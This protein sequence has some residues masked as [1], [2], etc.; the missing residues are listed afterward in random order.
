MSI[1]TF[2]LS[3]L[4]NFCLAADNNSS[5]SSSTQNRTRNDEVALKQEDNQLS[6]DFLKYVDFDARKHFADLKSQLVPIEAASCMSPV[7]LKSLQ[8]ISNTIGSKA[9][10]NNSQCE[11]YVHS[12][13]FNLAKLFEIGKPPQVQ[14]VIFDAWKN[15]GFSAIKFMDL[16]KESKPHLS[17]GGHCIYLGDYASLWHFKR[18]RFL[19]MNEEDSQE[20]RNHIDQWATINFLYHG[21]V[22]LNAS[23][24]AEFENCIIAESFDRICT[25]AEKIVKSKKYPRAELERFRVSRLIDTE[26][27]TEGSK[28][29]LMASAF[30][31]KI[32][33]AW[34]EENYQNIIANLLSHGIHFDVKSAVNSKE[35]KEIVNAYEQCISRAA[36]VDTK[37]QCVQAV[38]LIWNIASIKSDVE[39]LQNLFNKA[40]GPANSECSF[41]LQRVVEPAII[42]INSKRILE[43]LENDDLFSK[44]LNTNGKKLRKNSNSALQLENVELCNRL[45]LIQKSGDYLRHIDDIAYIRKDFDKMTKV[46][47]TSE[48]YTAFLFVDEVIQELKRDREGQRCSFDLHRGKLTCSSPEMLESMVYMQRSELACKMLVD[49]CKDAVAEKSLATAILN[50][51]EQFDAHLIAFRAKFSGIDRLKPSCILFY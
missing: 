47:N 26:D 35:P 18:G 30:D 7:Q 25:L 16:A 28:I 49:F 6:T 51:E 33:L 29:T 32:R 1:F 24:N 11:E 23:D 8:N 40:K 27:V 31:M 22:I 9:L 21:L 48:R 12:A 45:F 43:D 36:N 17:D 13:N 38:H 34:E 15:S 5:N 20:G 50:F 41:M 2:A 44:Q 37:N 3:L 42:L 10:S 4:V 14:Q 19:Q 39:T 46:F